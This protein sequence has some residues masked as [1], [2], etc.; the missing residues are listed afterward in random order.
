M[1]PKGSEVITAA[2]L[3]LFCGCHLVFSLHVGGHNRTKDIS[4]GFIT[5]SHDMHSLQSLVPVHAHLKALH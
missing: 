1:M 4:A 3:A 2:S 5:I